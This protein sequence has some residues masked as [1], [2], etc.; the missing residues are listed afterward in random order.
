[1]HRRDGEAPTGTLVAPARRVLEWTREQVCNLNLNRSRVLLIA[2][3][4]SVRSG[5]SEVAAERFADQLRGGSSLGLGA[6][7][8]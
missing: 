6:V 3:R 5:R 7:E 1:M 8:Q 2:S 4:G